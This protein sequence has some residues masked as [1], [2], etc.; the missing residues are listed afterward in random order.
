M[1]QLEILEK[2]SKRAYLSLLHGPGERAL[3][4]TELRIDRSREDSGES[5]GQQKDQIS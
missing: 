2:G 1:I 4:W 3:R 5:L